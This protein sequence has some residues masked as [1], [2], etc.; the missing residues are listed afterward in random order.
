[1]CVLY[2][3]GATAIWADTGAEHH[4]LYEAIDNCEAYLKKLH[5]DFTLV[6]VKGKTKIRGEEVDSLDDAIRKWKYMP[7]A[8]ARYCTRIFKIEPIDDYLKSQG[9]C[10]LLIGFNADEEPSKDRTGNYMECKN[11]LYRYPL[12]EDGYTREDCEEILTEHNFHPNFPIY[13]Q[14][15]G[16]RYCIYKS[17]AEYKALYLFDNETFMQNRKLEEE[18]QDKREKFF[19]MSVTQRPF[20]DI[21]NEIEQEIK[22]WGID[23]V[24]S[25]YK[26]I[27]A[28]EPCGAFCHR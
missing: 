8:Q 17:A 3:K 10:E 20:S 27:S 22:T 14:R 5:G 11:V 19:A 15:G 26:K 13:M 28:H 6:R 23:E 1:M 12:Y 21:Q 9:D 2:G 4:E 7:T 25:W 16:C 18:V 24:K